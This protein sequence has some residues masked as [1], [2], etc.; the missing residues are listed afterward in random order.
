MAA[1]LRATAH[2]LPNLTGAILPPLYLYLHGFLSS[3][4][5]VKAQQAL[6]YAQQYFPQIDLCVPP[7][8]NTLDL[9]LPILDKMAVQGR[10]L[11]IIGS[12]MGGFMATYLLERCEGK[13]VLINPAVDPHLLMQRYVGEHINPYTKETFTIAPEHIQLLERINPQVKRLQDF[14]VLLQTE[15]ETLDYRLAVNK[16]QGAKMTIEPGGDHSFVGFE[17][18]LPEIFAFLGS[19]A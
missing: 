2:P 13:A 1:V 3:P 6:K 17:R 9:A 14:W 16:Y 12:S 4:A 19:Q 8:P 11:R 7:L 5:S 15:D 18:Y 10:P